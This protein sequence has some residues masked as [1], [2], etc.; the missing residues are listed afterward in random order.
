MRVLTGCFA[1]FVVCLASSLGFVL[2][3]LA[4]VPD[5]SRY[6]GAVLGEPL[7][8]EE[9]A[10]PVDWSTADAIAQ[11]MFPEAD[12]GGAEAE[13]GGAFASA[14]EA[15]RQSSNPLGGDFM[16]WINEWDINFNQGD[17]TTETRNTYVHIFQPV[18]P[19]PLKFIGDDWIMVNRPT[20][21]FI[22]DTEVPDG[23]SFPL[24]P[25]GGPPQPP[26]G[27]PD[28]DSIPSGAVDWINR[29]GI[30]D[31]TS[32]HLVGI[33]RHQEHE[34]FFGE[35]DLVLA[36]GLTTLF[37]TGTS[38]FTA[39]VYALGPS[40]VGAWIGQK[41]IVG[42]LGQFWTK[43]G[44]GGQNIAPDD[45]NQMTLQAFYFLN[46]PGGW[47]V[48]GTPIISAD[49]EARSG[50]KW[51]VPIGLGVYK[52]QLF[53]LGKAM[54]PIKFGWEIN[55]VWQRPDTF[56]P[57]WIMKFNITPITPNFLAMAMG[58]SEGPGGKK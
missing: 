46:F 1:R 24:G 29:G 38:G 50:D 25:G 20:V 17:I 58:L 8:A 11:A 54:M 21:P 14:D 4:G 48:G 16:V 28:P 51:T 30:G 7:E 9:I 27:G 57:E 34:N 36:G 2:P 3:A 35:G 33:S 15:A 53:K 23:F 44:E 52:T 19:I 49:F 40:A 18:I 43:V 6:T 13:E 45:Y 32:F 31:L 26:P 5:R 41:F 42:M 56:G 39:D 47:Q 55:Y 10:G 37:P 12:P 22:Y